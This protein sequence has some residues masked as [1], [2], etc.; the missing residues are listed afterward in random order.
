MI[1][2]P[3]QSGLS[4]N[5]DLVQNNGFLTNLFAKKASLSQ[6]FIPPA[7]HRIPKFSVKIKL[8]EDQ[9]D[10]QRYIL[11]YRSPMKENIS[12]DLK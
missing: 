6:F 12:P 4:F 3:C 10:T 11:V 2:M 9:T 1:E 8:D 7:M 5:H